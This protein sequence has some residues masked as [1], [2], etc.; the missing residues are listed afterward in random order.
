LA[1]RRVTTL[2]AFFGSL[3]GLGAWFVLYAAAY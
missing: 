3:V 1:A 2:T